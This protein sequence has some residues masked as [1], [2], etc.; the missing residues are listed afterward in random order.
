MAGTGEESEKTA[1]VRGA[2]LDA[3][4]RIMRSEG[5][6]AVTSR[7][8]AKQAGLKSHLLHYYYRTMDQ[9]FVAVWVRYEERFFERQ[10]SVLGSS[11]P[12]KALWAMSTD[13]ADASLRQEFIALANHRK[14]IRALIARSARRN[15]KIQASAI[16]RYFERHGV[17]SVDLPPMTLV[18]L[19]AFVSRA[20]ITERN[21][22][23]TDNHRTI[24][25]YIKRHISFLEAECSKARR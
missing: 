2:I 13:S 6:A 5:Y 23:V 7:L 8:V 24:I 9:L 16:K 21:L 20:M 1:R 18:L 12:L 4:E 22:G 14:P 11:R 19:F 17:N 3:T 15:R 25:N 10:A